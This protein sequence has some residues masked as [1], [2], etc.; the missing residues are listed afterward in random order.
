MQFDPPLSSAVL[1]K[2]YKRFLADIQL[3]DG[4]VTTIHCANTG[5]M[6]GC[7]TPGD[8]VWFSHS[9]NP[10]RKYPCSWELTETTHGHQICVNTIRANTLAC[11]AIQSGVIKELQGYDTLRTE[12]KY[13]Q[14][15]SRI[16]IL[17]SAVSQP[18]CYIEVKSVT[19]L[20]YSPRDA[21][22]SG[23]GYFP[24]A[25]TTRGQKHLR[26]LMEVARNGKRAIL[27]FTVLHSGIENVSAAL[28]IDA[29]YSHLLEEAQKEGVEVL[30]YKAELS[31]YEMKLVSKIE[32]L[33][34][35]IK[36]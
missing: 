15:N 30:C 5:A 4:S 12:V 1:L 3:P 23:Q 35:P 31:K 17:L 33:N 29:T 20:D 22:P 24:D 16:D 26:E 21:K 6:T 27:L 2:R 11:E 18:D 28:H 7:A 13:G 32:W 25:V 14:E 36:Y 10:K 9:D 34:E 19:L 8:T